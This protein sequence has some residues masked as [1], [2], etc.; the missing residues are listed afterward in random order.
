MILKLTL[1]YL[2][3]LAGISS[4]TGQN[5]INATCIEPVNCEL[6]IKSDNNNAYNCSERS[7]PQIE[8][9]DKKPLDDLIQELQRKPEASRNPRIG[10]SRTFTHNKLWNENLKGEHIA[11][12]TPGVASLKRFIY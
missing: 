9:P 4:V 2:L 10:R 5:T 1:T 8:N 11:R 6:D 3:I 12:T 7:I